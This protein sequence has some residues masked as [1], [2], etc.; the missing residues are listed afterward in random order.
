MLRLLA[1]ALL[2]PVAGRASAQSLISNRSVHDE[3][4]VTPEQAR[5]LDSLDQSLQAESRRRARELQALSPEERRKTLEERRK[6]SQSGFGQTWG[7]MHRKLAEILS[8]EQVKRF[9]Q[10]T[11]QQAGFAAFRY[12]PSVRDRL[13]LTEDQVAKLLEV[14]GELAQMGA[15]RAVIQQKALEDPEGMRKKS[16]EATKQAI[17]KVVAIMTDEQKKTWADL[18][19]PPFQV[20]RERPPVP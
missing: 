5:K 16:D 2:V 19:G 14:E 15:S 1:L 4:K 13:K 6:N 8:P 9:D 11:V 7:D 10:I 17:A 12:H 3:L 20:K 18:T